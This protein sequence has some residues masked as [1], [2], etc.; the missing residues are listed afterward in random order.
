MLGIPEVAVELKPIRSTVLTHVFRASAI[1]CTNI[2]LQL[3]EL[4]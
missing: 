3:R 4:A 1:R 2:P